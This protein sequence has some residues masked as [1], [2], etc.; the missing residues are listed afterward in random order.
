VTLN[1]DEIVTD[2][3]ASPVD[4]NAGDLGTTELD[5]GNAAG[6]GN[7]TAAANTL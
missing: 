2:E 6:L 3:N 5:A 7:E 1:T 4:A